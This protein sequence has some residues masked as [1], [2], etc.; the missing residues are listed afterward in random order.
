MKRIALIFSVAGA[1]ALSALVL[2]RRASPVSVPTPVPTPVTIVQPTPPTP[3]IPEPVSS[4][5]SLIMSWKLSDPDLALGGN[6]DEYLKIDLTGVDVE[7][8]RAPMN[9]AVVLDRSGS[10]AGEKLESARRAA[11]A[12]VDRLNEKDRLAFVTFGSNVTLLFPSTA[13]TPEAKGTMHRDIDRIYDM[14]GTNLSGGLEAG[15][16]QVEAH[17]EGYAV[18]HVLLISDGEA[19]E[20]IT[21]R[22]GLAAIS[23]GALSHR[24][25]VSAF[26]VGTDFDEDTMQQLADEGGGNYRFLQTG[27]ELGPIFDTEL[28]Q[29]ATAVAAGP[30]LTLKLAPGVVATEVYGYAYDNAN[31]TVTIHLPDFAAGEHRK[32]VVQLSVPANAL[33]GEKLVDTK[34][35]YVDLIHGKNPVQTAFAASANIVPNA[36][37]ASLSRDKATYAQVARVHAASVSRRAATL[38]SSGD[39]A[40]AQRELAKGRGE[41]MQM[42]EVAQDPSLGADLDRIAPAPTTLPAAPSSEAGKVEAKKMKQEA[43]DY[44]R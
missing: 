2:G 17:L 10:M 6:R 22:P 28:K 1:L 43:Y 20:G 44:S 19:N 23:R 36:E 30:S 21:S 3:P 4:S 27:G 16:R 11:H 34:L 39:V 40:A 14:G 32:V 37:Q 13:C 8:Q 18:N 12:L 25:T 42:N 33:G 9:V 35:D 26:G 41:A 38:Y 31:G 7:G 5:G 15:L 24:V 29:M